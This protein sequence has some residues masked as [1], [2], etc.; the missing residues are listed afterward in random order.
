M[1]A[2]NCSN[3]QYKELG[4]VTA[5]FDT[6]LMSEYLFPILAILDFITRIIAISTESFSM[7]LTKTLGMKVLFRI[8]TKYHLKILKC[9]VVEEF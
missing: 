3:Q 7:S 2:C 5:L 9:G 1:V 8:H 6:K 4:L